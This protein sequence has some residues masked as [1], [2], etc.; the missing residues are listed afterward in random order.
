MPNV[1]LAVTGE[2]DRA[3]AVGLAEA[4]ATEALGLARAAGYQAQREAIGKLPTALVAVAGAIA[5]GK[6][7][8]M[9]DVLVTGGSSVEGL[10]ATLVRTFS[11]GT[12][13]PQAPREA[14]GADGEGLAV[15]AVP[16]QAAT[17]E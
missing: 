5:D 13:V 9:P 12:G 4:T 7:D 11:N 3:Q 16:A 14:V 17:P 1:I 15:T 10:A 8:I 6:I 2:A